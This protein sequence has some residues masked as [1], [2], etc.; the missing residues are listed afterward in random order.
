MK[1]DTVELYVVKDILANARIT[2][3]IPANSRALAVFGF[4]QFVESEIEKKKLPKRNYSLYQVGEMD[5][6]GHI[7]PMYDLVCNGSDADEYFEQLQQ[8]LY[9]EAQL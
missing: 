8:R 4:V 1:S 5:S 3:A 7:T 6:D 2:D 9:D